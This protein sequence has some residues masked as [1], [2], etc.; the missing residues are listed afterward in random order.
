MPSPDPTPRRCPVVPGYVLE[1]LLGRGGTGEVWRARPR[2]SGPPVAIKVLVHGDPDRQVREAAML[3]ELDHPHLV[4]LHEVVRRRTP[5]GV[6]VALVLDLLAG[7]SLAALLAARGRLRPGEVV[8]AIAPVAAALAHV[9]ERGIVHGDLS[10]G[11]VVLTA[12]GRPVLTDLGVARPVGAPG[13][14]EVTPPYVDPVVARGGAAGPAS[15]VFG[16]AAAAF[17]ALTGIPPWNAAGP[18]GTLAVAASGQV[19]DLALLAPEAPEDLVAVVSRGL[20]PQPHLRGSAA[21]FALDLRHACRPER[22]TLPAP[23]LDPAALHRSDHVP[24][25]ELTHQVR[26]PARAHAAP[27]PAGR[28]AAL[29]RRIAAPV[30]EGRGVLRRAGALLA[31]TAAVLTAV[32]VGVQW[33]SPD[34]GTVPAARVGAATP[35]PGTAPAGAPTSAATAPAGGA[36]GGTPSAGGA[37]GVTTSGDAASDPPASG[38]PVSGAPGDGHGDGGQGGSGVPA[39]STAAPGDRAGW[40]ELVAELYDR[41]AAAFTAGRPGDL[42]GVYAAGSPLL[43]LDAGRLTQLAGAGQRLVGFAPEVVAVDEA[44]AVPGG[45]RLLLTDRVPGYTVVTGGAGEPVAARGDASVVMTV[46]ATGSGWRI[47]TAAF[48]P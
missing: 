12:E 22:I 10:P 45:V 24:R 35:G 27:E 18:G 23:G 19:P 38:A 13:S 28:R 30:R 2:G 33:G 43:T 17:H 42:A 31:V 11:N 3:A 16:V 29:R 7:G 1:E 21:E 37:S 46:L 41:R 36:S 8:T 9:H 44:T 15:D 32:W 20:S 48:A 40:A 14:G 47:D 25:T 5:D 34:A 6:Q 4:R 39:D 26:R